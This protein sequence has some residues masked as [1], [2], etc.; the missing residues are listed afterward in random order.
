MSKTGLGVRWPNFDF[1]DA[2]VVWSSNPEC[3]MIWNANSTSAP[4]VEPWLNRVMMLA[5]KQI[6]SRD[7]DKEDLL[8][9]IDDFVRQESNH[10]RMHIEFNKVLDK[11]G[12][13]MPMAS[14]EKM[15]NDLRDMTRDR[16]LAFNAAYCAGFENFTLFTAKFMFENATDLFEDGG[17]PGTDLWL[18][19]MAEEYEHRSVCHDVFAAVSGNYFIRIYGM[20][21]SAFHLN[22]CMSG[23][24]KSFLERYREGMT[25]EERVQSVRREKDYK[26]RYTFYF[27]PRMLAILVPFYNPKHSKA[28][29]RLQRALDRFTGMSQ[30]PPRKVSS[31]NG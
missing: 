1:T 13:V 19:H 18:W 10:Y 15:K 24:I 12:Y 31:V 23:V 30:D 7:K 25:D 22:R 26:R 2:D 8:K 4:I 6:A 27:L 14:E 17:P 28:S 29:V 3:S 11:A 20:A 5:K 16:S 9:V 21:Y